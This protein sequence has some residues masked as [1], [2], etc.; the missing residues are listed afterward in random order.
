MAAVIPPP[1]QALPSGAGSQESLSMWQNPQDPEKGLVLL[2][3]P[4][5]TSVCGSFHFNVLSQQAATHKSTKEAGAGE[6]EV[7]P[8]KKPHILA[9]GLSPMLAGFWR[10]CG[11]SQTLGLSRERGGP[12]ISWHPCGSYCTSLA[13]PLQAATW[14]RNWWLLSPKAEIRREF[15]ELGPLDSTSLVA[16]SALAS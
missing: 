9:G 8:F 5:T 6:K 1:L 13:C 15:P 2:T 12:S 3:G 11:L 7:L 16:G 10:P 14:D 4:G